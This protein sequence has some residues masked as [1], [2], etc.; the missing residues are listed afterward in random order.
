[1]KTTFSLL[2]AI[3]F[4]L[5]LTPGS[6]AHAD[7]E[8]GLTLGTSFTYQGELKHGGAPADGVF[9]FEYELYDRA[10]GGTFLGRITELDTTVS[11]GVFTAELDFGTSITGAAVWLEIRVRE[12]GGGSFTVLTPRQHLTKATSTACTVDSD[13]VVNGAVGASGDRLGFLDAGGNDDAGFGKYEIFG[14]D[15][16]TLRTNDTD[17]LFVSGGGNLGIGVIPSVPLDVV[18]GTDASL[19]GGGFVV[20]GPQ[21]GTN[22][23]IDNNEIIARNAGGQASLHLN[24]DGGDVITGGDLVVGGTLDIGYQHVTAE[25]SGGTQNW[26]TAYCPAGKK[27]ISGGCHKGPGGA[28]WTITLNFPDTATSWHCAWQASVPNANLFRTTA[29]CASVD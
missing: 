24:H 10:E 17:Q 20:I 1:M 8:Y 5:I 19:G 23:V 22:I 12:S 9:D 11:S 28:F 4:T 13:L 21:N 18:G 25:C 29:V 7:G 3:A 14:I 6:D 15:F 2:T 27:V 26:C 16:L